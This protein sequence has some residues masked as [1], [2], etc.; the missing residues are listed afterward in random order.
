MRIKEGFVKQQIG[1]KTVL[2]STGN[3]SRDFRGMIELNY[4]AADIWDCLAQGKSQE[5]TAKFLAE[6]YG[7]DFQKA[8]QDTGKILEK[9]H[10]S[11]VIEYD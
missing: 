5:D 7:I 3:L 1:E 2:V 11:G 10:Q 4:T 6:K 9:M 8:L